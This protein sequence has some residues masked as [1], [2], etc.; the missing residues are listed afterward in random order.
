[1]KEKFATMG[2][3]GVSEIYRGQIDPWDKEA[4]KLSKVELIIFHSI[5][6]DF[7]RS[8]PVAVAEFVRGKLFT[9]DRLRNRR[10]YKNIMMI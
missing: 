4:E 7:P 5:R 6:Q 2:F 9:P 1:M 8:D 3:G 10:E